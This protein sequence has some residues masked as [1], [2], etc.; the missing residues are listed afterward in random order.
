MARRD[1]ERRILEA[2]NS[3][4]REAFEESK[5]D[6]SVGTLHL[7]LRFNELKDRT[8]LH[9]DTLAERLKSLRKEGKVVLSETGR[10]NISS[11]GERDLVLSNLL[12]LIEELGPGY[13]SVGGPLSDSIRPEE[14]T[15][16]R[17]TTLFGL[18]L[19]PLT[20]LSGMLRAFHGELAA[21][22]VLSACRDA[23]VPIE[24]MDQR[25]RRSEILSALKR[26]PLHGKQILVCV[27]DWDVWKDELNDAYLNRIA[28]V[29]RAIRRR[30]A[31]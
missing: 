15:V 4:Y 26:K 1:S 10:Y 31:T 9:Q 3:S 17:S 25:R 27:V 29:A 28:K 22:E 18:P 11:P 2:L 16:T 19:V 12:L 6:P 21:R 13:V 14:R 24:S 7:G 23:N 5:V 20:W 8:K 30:A